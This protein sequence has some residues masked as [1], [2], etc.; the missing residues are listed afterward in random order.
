MRKDLTHK[1]EEFAIVRERAESTAEGATKKIERAELGMREAEERAEEAES[2]AQEAEMR[3]A[4]AEKRVDAAEHEL[5]LVRTEVAGLKEKSARL[6]NM[7]EEKKETRAAERGEV[8]KL[9]EDFTELR[10][11]LML[12]LQEESSAIHELGLQEVLEASN[13]VPVRPTIISNDLLSDDEVTLTLI[14]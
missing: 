4:T 12:T 7:E 11:Q 14:L 3:L 10:A 1:Q 9:K 6:V 2:R 13:E 5:V 8:E